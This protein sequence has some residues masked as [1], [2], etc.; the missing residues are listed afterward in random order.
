MSGLYTF[1][2]QMNCLLLSEG[3]SFTSSLRIQIILAESLSGLFS[4]GGAELRGEANI[5]IDIPV[6]EY[7][8]TDLRGPIKST[9]ARSYQLWVYT[10]CA[11]QNFLFLLP[12]NYQKA[13]SEYWLYRLSRYSHCRTFQPQRSQKEEFIGEDGTL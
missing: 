8:V 12:P 3:T 9:K 7:S 1:C 13:A 4:D 5:N 6:S 2:D 10:T 11:S